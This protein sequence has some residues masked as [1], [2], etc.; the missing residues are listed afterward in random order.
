M[1]IGT[2]L[3]RWLHSTRYFS[4]TKA[5]GAGMDVTGCPV[6]HCFH[7]FHIGLPS[8]VGTTAGVRHLNSKGNTLSA[9]ITFCHWYC[10]SLLTNIFLYDSKFLLK[11]QVFFLKILSHC[12][13]NAE[14]HF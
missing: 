13:F 3:Y 10:T 14:N 7:P 12:L 9:A 5:T 1:P 6:H 4:R 8:A 11:K 2:G